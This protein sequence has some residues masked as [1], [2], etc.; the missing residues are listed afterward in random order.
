[1][2]MTLFLYLTHTKIIL[3]IVEL[4]CILENIS[5]LNHLKFQRHRTAQ[6]YVV[7]AMFII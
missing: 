7:I 3:L 4:K 6:I 5:I 2:S 1:M